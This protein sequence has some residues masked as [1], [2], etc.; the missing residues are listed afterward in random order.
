MFVFHSADH[1]SITYNTSTNDN[2]NPRRLFPKEE[3]QIIKLVDPKKAYF[4]ETE[5]Y[6]DFSSG[7]VILNKALLVDN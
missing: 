2:N 7:N 5:Y 4:T 3:E 6:L 1:L